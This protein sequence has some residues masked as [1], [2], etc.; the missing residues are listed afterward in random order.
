MPSLLH[1]LDVDKCFKNSDAGIDELMRSGGMNWGV[2][3]IY[4]CK[5]S[6]SNR[7]D[8]VIVQDSV[9]GSPERR[10]GATDDSMVVAADDGEMVDN[11]ASDDDLDD[12]CEDSED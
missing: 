8:F 5:A 9:D 12:D 1:V 11:D 2:I 4:T 3:A 6:C 10:K 7:D